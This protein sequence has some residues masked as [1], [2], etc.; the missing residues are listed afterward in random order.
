MNP[1]A[2][3][4]SLNLK[5]EMCIGLLQSKI[6]SDNNDFD[7]LNKV[8]FPIMEKYTSQR[9]NEI[10]TSYNSLRSKSLSVNSSLLAIFGFNFGLLSLLIKDFNFKNNYLLSF[11]NNYIL[12]FIVITLVFII[13]SSFVFYKNINITLP[14]NYQYIHPDDVFRLRD[15]TNST[16][17]MI[18]DYFV[19]ANI[20]FRLEATI[21]NEY[22]NNKLAKKIC[23]IS[24]NIKIYC[25]IS[26]LYL[27]I[28]LCLFI[29]SKI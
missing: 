27:S 28:C 22:E 29:S 16:N 6:Q 5:R 10:Q 26:I 24:K 18:I 19:K 8:L 3:R 13:Y 23:S 11:C 9:E 12:F 4:K 7:V 20:S 25:S 1:E 17:E 14:D 15:D 2:D 21:D